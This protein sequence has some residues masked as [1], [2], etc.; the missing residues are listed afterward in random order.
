MSRDAFNPLD[1]ANLGAS[2]ANALLESPVFALRQL[3]PFAGAGIYA[4]YYSG[5]FELYLPISKL[6]KE[7]NFLMP[8]YV[9]KAVPPGARKGGLGLDMDPGQALYKRLRDHADSVISAEN[10]EI[11]DF[12]CRYLIVDD[13]WIALGESLLIAK[14]LPI[15]NSL[16]DGFGNH[17]PGG[18]Y[19]GARPRWDVPHPGRKWAD[20]CLPRNETKEEIHKEIET[21]FNLK[22][23]DWNFK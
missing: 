6:N 3:A 4:L 8:I 23:K 14:F 9:G 2:V 20:K 18:R 1:K 13:I 16:I 19:K 5:K 7:G 12:Y 10:L 11:E 21:Y 17:D 15:W 22:M